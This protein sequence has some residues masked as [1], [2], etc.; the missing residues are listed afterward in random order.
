MERGEGQAGQATVRK[1]YLTSNHQ[2]RS[3]YLNCK[4]EE[5]WLRGINFTNNSSQ[6]YKN[7][8]IKTATASKILLAG[9]LKPA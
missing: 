6:T 3:P 2:F 1:I 4:H 7:F 9:N 5:G 8:A